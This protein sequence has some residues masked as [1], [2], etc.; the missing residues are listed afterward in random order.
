MTGNRR[1]RF[2]PDRPLRTLENTATTTPY[3]VSGATILRRSGP[4]SRPSP[5]RGSTCGRA[6]T[7]TPHRR[8][9]APMP[10]TTRNRSQPP[11]VPGLT[12]PRSFRD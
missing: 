8:L 2:L 9:P 3:L 1:P 6:L 11:N 10:G 7:P 5:L 4:A 12:R